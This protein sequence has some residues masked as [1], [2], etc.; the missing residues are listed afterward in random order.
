MEE[1][2]IFVEEIV[3]FDFYFFLGNFWEDV[4][5]DKFLE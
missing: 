2:T 5:V 3:I 4:G 1:C